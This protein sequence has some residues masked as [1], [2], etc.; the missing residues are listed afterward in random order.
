MRI[1]VPKDGKSGNAEI[2]KG[3]YWVSLHNESQQIFL[4]A[5]GRDIKLPA[6]RRRNKARTKTVSV[7]FYSAGGA[8]WSLIVSTPKDG[9]DASLYQNDPG[10]FLDLQRPPHHIV[11]LRNDA[12]PVG[13]GD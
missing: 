9:I 11:G 6:T 5:G 13:F 10:C 8:Y 12:K 4:T 2:P 3:E 7:T 1:T